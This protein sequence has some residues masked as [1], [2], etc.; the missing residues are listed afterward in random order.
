LQVARV[1]TYIIDECAY[2]CETERIFYTR[3]CTTRVTK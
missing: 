3:V 1:V 2:T